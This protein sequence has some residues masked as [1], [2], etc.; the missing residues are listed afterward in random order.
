M[1]IPLGLDS[2]SSHYPQELDRQPTLAQGRDIRCLD[3]QLENQEEIWS[4][5]EGMSRHVQG[6]LEHKL[7]HMDRESDP[8]F[9]KLSNSLG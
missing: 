6:I 3:E 5:F 7:S 8:N 9:S 4:K 2:Q 1:G